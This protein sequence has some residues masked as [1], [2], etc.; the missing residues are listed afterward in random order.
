MAILALRS[1]KGSLNASLHF[2]VMSVERVSFNSEKGQGCKKKNAGNRART[3][4][5]R[6][7]NGI[8]RRKKGAVLSHQ[9]ARLGGGK[10][11]TTQRLKESAH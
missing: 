5:G 7:K 3:E 10:T 6:D 1:E 9:G 4:P 11:T 8:P 2:R